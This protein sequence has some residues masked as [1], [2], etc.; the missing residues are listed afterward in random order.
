M[1][2][3]LRLLLDRP[4]DPVAAWAV[5]A[6]ASA[7]LAGLGAVFVLGAD[8]SISSMTP[9]VHI[10]DGRPPSFEAAG[11][12]LT[13]AP[14]VRLRQRHDDPQDVKG[15][16]PARYAAETLHSHLA[17]QHVPYRHGTLTVRLVGA[18]RGRA[19]LAVSALSIAAAREGWRRFLGTY[20]DPG[21]S[22][23][24]I[25]RRRAEVANG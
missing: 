10:A 11:A 1:I 22:Y 24:P 21:H 14:P 25:F 3:R 17:L 5:V 23:I 12:R 15:T 4:L 8:E 7:A 9:L 19:V 6:L 18:R 16:R 13:E 2:D 20:H